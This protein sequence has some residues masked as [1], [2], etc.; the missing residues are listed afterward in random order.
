LIDPIQENFLF[1]GNTIVN[2]APGGWSSVPYANAN[3][4]GN[5]CSDGHQG[6]Q[7]Y[8]GGLGLWVTGGMD[9]STIT[10]NTFVQTASDGI[11]VADN[12]CLDAS[13]SAPSSCS[14]DIIA[15]NTFNQ[16]LR[17]GVEWQGVKGGCWSGTCDYSKTSTVTLNR[18]LKGNH[19]Y[20]ITKSYY[21]T[22]CYS[23]VPGKNTWYINN[24]AIWNPTS[25]GSNGA[26]AFEVADQPGI[27]LIQGNVVAINSAATKHF[28]HGFAVARPSTGVNQILQNNVQCGVNIPFNASEGKGTGGTTTIQLHRLSLS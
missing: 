6:C 1:K 7:D 28:G 4:A 9:N 14:N 13:S 11:T 3:E 19:C 17:I 8:N 21:Q 23:N 26:S 24:S 5:S 15:Y 12:A 22:W 27:E 10:Y 25:A 20:N 2:I 16:V 18:W